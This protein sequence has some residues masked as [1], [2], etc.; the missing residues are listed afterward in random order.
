MDPRSMG[1]CSPDA[2]IMVLPDTSWKLAIA[3]PIHTLDNS[4]TTPKPDYG[5]MV[6][7]LGGVQPLT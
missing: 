5:D 7:S 2:P 3:R 1:A 4:L 6:A